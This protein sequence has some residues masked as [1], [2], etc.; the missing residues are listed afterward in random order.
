ME[1]AI[2]PRFA[3]GTFAGRG[4]EAAAAASPL[5]DLRVARPRRVDAAAGR[6]LDPAELLEDLLAVGHAPVDLLRRLARKQEGG[7]G[8]VFG[9][10]ASRVVDAANQL[11]KDRARRRH[12][13]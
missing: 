13:L 12:D 7:L 2:S 9:R 10:L 6:L 11:V 8:H 1:E 4:R 3:S 5:S